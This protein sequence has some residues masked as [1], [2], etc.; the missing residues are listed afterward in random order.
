MEIWLGYR[1]RF[2]FWSQLA[3]VRSIELH[4]LPDAY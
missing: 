1:D 3:E 4:G 2:A